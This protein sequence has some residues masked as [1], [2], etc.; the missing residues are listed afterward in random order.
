[1]K[2]MILATVAMLVCVGMAEAGVSYKAVTRVKDARGREKQASEMTAVVDGLKAR[3]NIEA[4]RGGAVP[5]GGYLITHDGAKTVYMVNPKEKS[6]M[7]WDID[8]LAG[9]ATSIMANSGG[10]LNMTVTNHRSEKL[11]DEKGPALLG[12]PT[13]HYKF[14][15]SYSMEMSV[16]GFKQKSDIE[17]E[18]EI[19][20]G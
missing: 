15:T 4:K 19:W 2:R 3:I 18:Q 17:T 20:A 9:I 16:M 5:E 1:M 10:L 6:Y 7:K 11:L 14:L 13:R 8:K 12:V